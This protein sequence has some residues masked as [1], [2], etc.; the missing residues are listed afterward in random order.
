M[1]KFTDIDNPPKPITIYRNDDLDIIL[2]Y[3]Y[4]HEIFNDPIF[5]VFYEP[6][7]ENRKATLYKKYKHQYFDTEETARE[8]IRQLEI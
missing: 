8:F 6:D 7:F 5:D 1:Q 4:F 2:K 3:Y